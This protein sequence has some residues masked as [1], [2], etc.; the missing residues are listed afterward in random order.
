[1]RKDVKKRGGRKR[2]AY[3]GGC[4]LILAFGAARTTDAPNRYVP[5]FRSVE[6]IRGQAT[7]SRDRNNTSHNHT[8]DGW[9]KSVRIAIGFGGAGK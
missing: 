4:I 6:S 5:T 2:H 1:M 3:L 8:Q 7:E 9:R